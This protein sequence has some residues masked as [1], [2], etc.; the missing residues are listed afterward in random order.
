MELLPNR[1]TGDCEAAAKICLDQHSNCEA[2]F[3]FGEM[4]RACADSAFPSESDGALAG[5]YGPFFHGTTAGLAKRALHIFGANVESANVIEPA[6]VGFADDGIDATHFLVARLSQ[7][8]TRYCGRRVPD[9][10]RV[11]EY[12]GSFDLTQLH[13]LRGA[14]E[15][16]KRVIDING[17][18]NFVLKKISRVRQDCGNASANIFAFDDGDLAHLDAGDVSDGVVGAGV[19]DTWMDAELARTRAVLVGSGG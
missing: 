18:G 6:V 16:A 10:E 12:D 14:D 7:G 9:A 3:F 1:N 2:A 4:T 17:A 11:G 15:F 13:Y 19:V 5:A 8:P